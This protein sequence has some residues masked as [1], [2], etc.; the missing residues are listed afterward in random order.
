MQRLESQRVEP[1]ELGQGV[2]PVVRD[3]V[4]FCQLQMAQRRQSGKS[5]HGLVGRLLALVGDG[6]LDVC[7][8]R[9][10]LHMPEVRLLFPHKLQ[11]QRSQLGQPGQ[12]LELLVL[13]L[14]AVLERERA[15]GAHA[16]QSLDPAHRHLLHA[17]AQRLQRRKHAN[18]RLHHRVRD[19]VTVLEVQHAQPRAAGEHGRQFLV[20]DLRHLEAL[21]VREAPGQHLARHPRPALAGLEPRK[22]RV[23]Q[24][25]PLF[26]H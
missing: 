7:D 1:R 24:H 19:L 25:S 8:A 16:S 14:L 26:A 15:Q 4:A 12:R 21:Q 2:Q 18:Q 13:E 23:V 3:A 6:E 5:L 9:E 22:V 11:C 17:Q 10:Q 20:R